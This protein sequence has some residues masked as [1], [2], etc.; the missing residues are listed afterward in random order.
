M[1]ILP[2]LADEESILEE[3][4]KCATATEVDYMLTGTLYLTGGPKKKFLSFLEEDYE[5]LLENYQDLYP[6]GGA[7]PEYKAGVHKFLGQMRKNYRVN[8][9]YSQFLPPKNF[10]PG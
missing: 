6:R 5:D 9:N 8:N 3:M 7:D 4:V 2:Y 1:P 10:F